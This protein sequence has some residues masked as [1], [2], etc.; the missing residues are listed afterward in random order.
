LLVRLSNKQEDRPSLL[1]KAEGDLL[2][3]C[4]GKVWRASACLQ[5]GWQAL[6]QQWRAC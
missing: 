1:I 5:T 2:L 3:F 6:R 4:H